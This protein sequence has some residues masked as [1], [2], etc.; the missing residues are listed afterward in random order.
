[1]ALKEIPPEEA[2]RASQA[3]K[4]ALSLVLEVGDRTHLNRR[5]NRSY[6]NMIIEINCL[7]S[8]LRR[9]ADKEII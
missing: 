2:I 9:H 3:L 8:E 1:M 7:R 4:Q 5:T 6:I